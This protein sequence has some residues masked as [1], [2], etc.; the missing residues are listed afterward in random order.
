MTLGKSSERRLGDPVTGQG[1]KP[2]N[3]SQEEILE[4]IEEL[5]EGEDLAEKL[6]RMDSR[7]DDEIT[8]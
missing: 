2:K 3:R 6:R 8:S 5:S 7:A 4:L 1:L